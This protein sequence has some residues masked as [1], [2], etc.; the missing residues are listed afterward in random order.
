MA[1]Q[2]LCNTNLH[3]NALNSSYIF[4]HK[5]VFCFST[6]PLTAL[7]ISRDVALIA[8]VFYVRYKTVPPPVSMN[9]NP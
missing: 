8:A 1:Q 3:R 9:Q 5:L 4:D 2:T 6:V 7:V